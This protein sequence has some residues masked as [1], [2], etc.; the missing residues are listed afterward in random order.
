MAQPRPRRRWARVWRRRRRDVVEMAIV[1]VVGN[2]ENRVFP[3]PGHHRLDDAGEIAFAVRRQV[4]RVLRQEARRYDPGDVRQVAVLGVDLELGLSIVRAHRRI[5][6]RIGAGAHTA[7]DAICVLQ[8]SA[9]IDA[10][11]QRPTRYRR[12]RVDPEG[13]VGWREH[14]RRVR[15]LPSQPGRSPIL[16][17]VDL[18]GR[19]GARLG[20]HRW[21]A[22][23]RP[24]NPR[25]IQDRN[26]GRR[27]I[28][29]ECS[30]SRRR[31]R[32]KD[33]AAHQE[34]AIGPGRTE[35]RAK[36]GV[37]EK[38]VLREQPMVRNVVGCEIAHGRQGCCALRRG[39]S[40]HHPG[41]PPLSLIRWAVVQ[42][43][44][45]FPRG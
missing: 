11:W 44:N 10:E 5:M 30:R 16:I 21:I 1:L 6:C 34:D 14:L 41:R 12:V 7:I 37:A 23:P 13:E 38:K 17:V 18:P 43:R 39:P 27:L 20:E 4:H 33:R 29:D 8:L 42:R 3:V 40:V 9:H 45:L 22:L 35:N 15:C 28:R 36:V 24:P 26:V 31:G 25:V 19:R 2:D 32:A